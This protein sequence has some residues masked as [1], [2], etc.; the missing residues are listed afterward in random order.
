MEILKRSALDIKAQGYD[1][2]NLVHDS[3]WTNVRDEKEVRVIQGIMEDWTVEA[4]DLP[5]YTE[6]KRLRKCVEQS[7]GTA[8]T[9]LRFQ[10]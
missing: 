4:F 6:A 2:C 9:E 5:F 3:V 1:I 10:T 7:T 8:R